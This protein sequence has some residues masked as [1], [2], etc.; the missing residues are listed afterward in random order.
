M[1]LSSW[2]ESRPYSDALAQAA[3]WCLLMLFFCC[4]IY[5]YDALTASE[6]VQVKMSSEQVGVAQAAR[7]HT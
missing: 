5:K 1:L 2:F 7:F 6:D 4:I 3:S